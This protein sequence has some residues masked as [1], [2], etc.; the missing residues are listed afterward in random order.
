MNN[1]KRNTFKLLGLA[2]AMSASSAVSLPAFASGD[3]DDE[4][5]RAGKVFTSTNAV[6]GNE[7]L[8]YGTGKNG[9]LTLQTR[10]A[11]QGAGTGTGMGNQA[12]SRSVATAGTCLS[13]MR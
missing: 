12:V 4:G 8:V 9:Q 7:L 10:V 6:T 13:S 3:E 2:L 5:F 11:T 1:P